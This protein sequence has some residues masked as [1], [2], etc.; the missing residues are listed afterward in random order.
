M[1]LWPL[2]F[3]L[4]KY[5]STTRTGVL[6]LSFPQLPQLELGSTYVPPRTN[7]LKNPRFAG[8]RVLEAE[9]HATLAAL[10]TQIT[11]L[12]LLSKTSLKSRLM[13]AKPAIATKCSMRLSV[14]F[15][16]IRRAFVLEPPSAGDR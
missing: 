10:D 13:E 12:E 6:A 4:V 5:Q 7:D 11:F 15:V 2:L 1:T 3:S 8:N 16:L 14:A 9:N